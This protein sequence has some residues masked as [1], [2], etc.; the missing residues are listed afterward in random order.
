MGQKWDNLYTNM[1]VKKVSFL[2]NTIIK[3]AKFIKCDFML[4]FFYSMSKFTAAPKHGYLLTSGDLIK[5][6]ICIMVAILERA[7]QD[8]H[9]ERS[10]AVLCKKLTKAHP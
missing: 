4:I 9:F 6:L 5:P 7:H 8:G 3:I 1:F 10:F 2:L